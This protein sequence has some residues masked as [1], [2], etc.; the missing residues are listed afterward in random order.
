MVAAAK[1]A[2]S[3]PHGVVIEAKDLT[4]HYTVKLGLFRGHAT[5]LRFRPEDGLKVLIHGLVGLYEARGAYQIVVER[6]EPAGLGARCL[7]TRL[8]W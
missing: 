6:M 2:A 5:A 4:R 1:P 8:V 7:L 3:A